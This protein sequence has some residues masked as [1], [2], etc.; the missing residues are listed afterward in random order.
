VLI[1]EEMLTPAVLVLEFVIVPVGLIAAVDKVS[2]PFPS[3]TTMRLFVPVTPPLK[4]GLVPLED[5]I[6]S[7]AVFPEAKTIGFANVPVKPP[8]SVEVAL[9]LVLPIVIT[10]EFAPK[11]FA[12]EVP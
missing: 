4:I 9:P 10:L 5:D 2:V 7:G 1:T 12:F 11:A 6:I 3:V 8:L